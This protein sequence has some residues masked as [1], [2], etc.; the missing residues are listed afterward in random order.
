MAC[1]LNLSVKLR[2]TSVKT[3]GNVDIL[4]SIANGL[5]NHIKDPKDS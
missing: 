3:F 2:P 4:E 1:E 5:R